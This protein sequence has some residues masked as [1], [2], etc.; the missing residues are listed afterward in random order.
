MVLFRNIFLCFINI[1]LQCACR[2]LWHILEK[3][4]DRIFSSL[5]SC[6]DIL[7][8]LVQEVCKFI[9]ILVTTVASVCLC[10]HRLS[11]Y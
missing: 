1:L 11:G 2:F 9:G 4:R 6:S 7:K 10:I 8:Y 5:S 3:A